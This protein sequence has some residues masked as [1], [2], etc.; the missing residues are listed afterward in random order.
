[1]NKSSF[2][3]Q[4]S[5]RVNFKVFRTCFLRFGSPW[6]LWNLEALRSHHLF[7]TMPILM[8]PEPRKTT[9]E[10]CVFLNMFS[11]IFSLKAC[12]SGHLFPNTRPKMFKTWG[13]GQLCFWGV[14]PGKLLRWCAPLILESVFGHQTGRRG[15]YW[16]KTSTNNCQIFKRK[17]ILRSNRL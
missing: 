2:C 12:L 11:N 9:F 6:E 1:M 3:S 14:G 13:R 4:G 17:P 5:N 8:V 16:S 15:S 7:E 10:E